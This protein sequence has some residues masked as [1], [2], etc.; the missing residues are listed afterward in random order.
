MKD[1]VLG[2]LCTKFQRPA[3]NG[4]G[5]VRRQSHRKFLPR[6]EGKL[7]RMGEDDAVV[8]SR[9]STR[10]L[11]AAWRRPRDVRRLEDDFYS[12]VGSHQFVAKCKSRLNDSKVQG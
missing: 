12:L 6:T 2:Q 9:A 3:S 5:A 11:R 1:E 7:K 4:L 10:L 8:D